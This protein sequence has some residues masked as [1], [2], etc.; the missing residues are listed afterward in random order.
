MLVQKEQLVS[1]YS[2]DRVAQI[3]GSS[4]LLFRFHK[5]RILIPEK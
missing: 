4:E 5:H 2:D 1:E 3:I